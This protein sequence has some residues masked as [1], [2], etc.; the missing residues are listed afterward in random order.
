MSY[1]HSSGGAK[2]AISQARLVLPPRLELEG[3]DKG[4]LE[5]LTL[6]TDNEGLG[7]SQ[8]AGPL[9]TKF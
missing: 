6:A 8:T 2:L 7:K 5:R 9:G 4:I 3:T 1:F